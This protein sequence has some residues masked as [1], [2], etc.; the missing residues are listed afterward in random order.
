[1]TIPAQPTQIR[2]IRVFVSS[3]FRDMIGERDELMPRAWPAL[4]RFCRQRQV[5]LVEVAL[6]RETLKLW[7]DKIRVCRP[8]FIGLRVSVIA[9][10]MTPSLP[11]TAFTK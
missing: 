8:L 3:T 5:E 4:R 1:M 7:L 6:R 9:G 11:T 2:R 10:P